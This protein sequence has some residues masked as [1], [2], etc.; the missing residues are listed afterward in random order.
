MN[1]KFSFKEA[2]S[3]IE[4]RQY[5]ASLGHHAVRQNGVDVLYISN[6]KIKEC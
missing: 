4:I 6:K 1:D 5:L 2:K 3:R